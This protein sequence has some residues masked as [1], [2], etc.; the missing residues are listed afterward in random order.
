M[1]TKD[2]LYN[3]CKE[4]LLYFNDSLNMR[5]KYNI[6]RDNGFEDPYEFISK[7]T[8]KSFILKLCLNNDIK[9]R[10]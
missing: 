8:N 5:S 6:S 4:Y 10:L 9:R 3:N 7:L 1:N 2:K